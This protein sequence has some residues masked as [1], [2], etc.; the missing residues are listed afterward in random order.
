MQMHPTPYT[1]TPLTTTKTK[2]E[3]QHAEVKGYRDV[4]VDEG[5]TQKNAHR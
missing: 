1:H 4:E 5:E 3:I 2:E